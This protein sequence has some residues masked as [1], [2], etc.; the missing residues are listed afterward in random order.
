MQDRESMIPTEVRERMK[1]VRHKVVVLSGKGGVGKSTV[2]ANLA[3]AFAKSDVKSGILDVDI[4]GPTIPKILG[5]QGQHPEVLEKS[6][7]PVNGPLDVK[8]M[9]MGFLL[10]NADDAVA[11]RGPLVAKAISQ[12]LSDVEWGDLDLLVVDLPP[13]TGDEILSILQLIPSVDGTLIVSTPQE[14][15]V[16]GARRAIQLTQ[17][18]GVR[19]LGVVENMGEFV[20]PKCGARYRLMGEGAV[21]RA[22]RDYGIPYLGSIPMDPSISRLTDE[23]TPFVIGQPD[24]ESAKSFAELCRRISE[25]IGL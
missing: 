9:S 6:I 23:G 11:W 12:F 24:S 20:C 16:L 25:S 10:R 5:L 19:V 18:M 1:R 14:V 3:M 4:Y 8:V 7:L 15:A 2:S 22:A 21:E 13:G 17:R